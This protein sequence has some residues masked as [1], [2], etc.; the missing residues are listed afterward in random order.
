MAHFLHAA[1]IHLDRSLPALLE[2]RAQHPFA[3][4]PRQAFMRLI[5]HA[6]ESEAAFLVL[7]GDIYDGSWKD[8]S[9]GLFLHQQLGRLRSHDIPVYLLHGNHDAESAMAKTLTPPANVHRFSAKAPETVRFDP[10]QVALHGQSFL[11]ADTRDNLASRYPA[12]VAG[13][14]NI[15]VL[16]T[17]LAGSPPHSPYAPCTLEQLV[18]HGYDYW[19]LGH[20]HQHKIL[21]ATP[22]VVFPGNLQALH[23]KELGPRGAVSV[24]IEDGRL[25]PPTFVPLDVLRFHL[26]QAEVPDEV[27]TLAELSRW[28]RDDL[29][30]ALATADGRHLA[31][32][33]IVRFDVGTHL[34]L[35]R[36]SAAIGDEVRGV[37]A[38][39]EEDATLESIDV[40]WRSQPVVAEAGVAPDAIA[41]L[42]QYFAQAAGDPALMSRLNDTLQTVISKRKAGGHDD[43]TQRLDALA[44]GG[45]GDVLQAVAERLRARLRSLG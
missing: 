1:D 15:G 11:N 13:H 14:L 44:Q 23:I 26:H 39:F 12:P 7:A 22:H 31:V 35:A 28:I 30:G 20:V 25:G 36:A 3:L 18:A 17:A 42:E 43:V 24:P 29:E 37:F 45:T 4:A 8:V 19:A 38:Q 32:R 16:H 9:T 21:H 10:L 2:Q 27:Q 5:D 33:V 41:T 34:A 40:R 6:I